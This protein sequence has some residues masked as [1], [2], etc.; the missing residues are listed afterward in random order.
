MVGQ[1]TD[2]SVTPLDLGLAIKPDDF[3]GRRS[4]ARPDTARTDRKQL[5]GLLADDPN[6][7]LPEG[8]QVI[9]EPQSTAMLGHVTSGYFGARIGRGFALALISGGRQRHDTPVYAYHLGQTFPARICL[10][11]FYD[12]EGR[13]RDG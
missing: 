2:G 12:R 6:L 10:P 8:A 1:E 3:L 5:V 13:R 11:V 9:A 4:L 7:V